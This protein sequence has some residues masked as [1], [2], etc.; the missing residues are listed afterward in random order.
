MHPKVGYNLDDSQLYS[1]LAACCLDLL[2]FRVLYIKYQSWR[3]DLVSFYNY[4]N[5]NNDYQFW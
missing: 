3:F 2:K 4:S 1:T 5:C